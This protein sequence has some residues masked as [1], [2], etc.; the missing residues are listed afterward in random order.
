MA[1]RTD[2]VTKKEPPNQNLV[3]FLLTVK[4]DEI[5][6]RHFHP[7]E[8]ITR[9]VVPQPG[10]GRTFIGFRTFRT[11]DLANFLAAPFVPAVEREA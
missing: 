1:R 4:A 10:A 7:A 5:Q 6:S 11:T 9:S 3:K 8:R 2:Y